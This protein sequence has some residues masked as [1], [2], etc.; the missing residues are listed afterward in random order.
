MTFRDG[1]QKLMVL[2]TKVKGVILCEGR[3]RGVY[4]W[5]L[6]LGGLLPGW[7]SRHLCDA[8]ALDGLTPGTERKG[9]P[10]G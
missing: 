2:T 9:V 1:S 8:P 4:C 5:R 7:G 6:G 3:E 10:A